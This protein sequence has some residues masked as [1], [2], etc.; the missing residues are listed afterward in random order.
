MC[1]CSVRN[2]DVDLRELDATQ[3]LVNDGM[4]ER[5]T[6][7]PWL[8]CSISTADSGTLHSFTLATI[9]QIETLRFCRAFSHA[10]GRRSGRQVLRSE[11]AAV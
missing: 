6:R 9:I 3:W 11:G 5:G 10:C 4:G 8:S 1:T 2:P 7:A